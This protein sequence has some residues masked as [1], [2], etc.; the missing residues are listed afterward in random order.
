[1]SSRSIA[2]LI[3]FISF[4]V[5]SGAASATPIPTSSCDGSSGFNVCSLYESDANGNLSD[6]SQVSSAFPDTPWLVGYTFVLDP[7]TSYAGTTDNKNIS[8]VVVI[9]STFAELFSLGDPNFGIAVNSAL[10]LTAI[11]GN[12]L[13][14]GQ[15]VGT[16]FFPGAQRFG[17]VG[18]VNEDAN[19]IALLPD[20][21][22]VGGDGDQITVYSGDILPIL[23]PPNIPLP[24][25]T[26]GEVPEPT[27]IALLGTGV[28]GAGL[29]RWRARRQA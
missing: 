19:G 9:H 12:S 20:L 5:M 11:D 26:N 27:T 2:P 7:G 15:I 23:G 25:P 24:P 6:D 4:G 29:R 8:D 22:F 13:A 16:P 10:N 1:M 18:L 3:A 21:F 14:T 17:G 28:I